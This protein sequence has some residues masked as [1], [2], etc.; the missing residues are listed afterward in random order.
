MGFLGERSH[1]WTNLIDNALD[2]MEATSGQL[3]VKTTFCDPFVDVYISDTGL[4]ISEEIKSKIFDPFFTTK[5]LPHLHI[6]D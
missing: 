2:A 4:G 5:A 6:S 1:V 3:S